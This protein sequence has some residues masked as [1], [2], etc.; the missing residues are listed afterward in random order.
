RGREARTI[1]IDVSDPIRVS[2]AVRAVKF[3]GYDHLE[4]EAEV[5]ALYSAGQSKQEVVEGV[6]VDLLTTETPFYGE[7]GGQVGDRGIIETPRGDLF[8]VLDTQHPTPQLTVHKGRVK[9]GRFQVGDKVHLVV[10]PRYRQR[11]MLNHS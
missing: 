10:D 4:A 5:L 3:V 8:E 2:D 1:S 7:S 9:K 11:T 6:E